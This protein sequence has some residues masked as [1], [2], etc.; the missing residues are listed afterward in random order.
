MRSRLALVLLFLA[1]ILAFAAPAGALEHTFS[2]S[3]QLD[4]LGVPTQPSWDANGGTGQTFDGFTMEAAVKVSADITDHLSANV[5]VCFGC[6]GFELDMAYFDLRVADELNFRVGRFSPSFG[7]FTLRHDPA[8]QKLSDKPLP[9]DMGRMLRNMAW[10]YSVLPS[11]F[12]DNGAEID[13]THWFGSSAQLDYAAYA[14]AGF[15]NTDANPT[16]IN[17]PLSH[18]YPYAYYVDNNARPAGG[19]RLALTVKPSSSSDI[20]VG[21]SGMGGTYDNNDRLTYIILG[22]DASVRIHRTNIRAEYLVRRTEISTLPGAQ[23]GLK[24]AIAADDGNYFVKHG[25]YVELEQPVVH[26][27]DAIA[28]VDGM[29]RIGNVPVGSLLTEH[30]WMVRETLG[31]AYGI[32]RNLRL[33][34]SVEYYEFSEADL[35]GNVRDLAFHVGVTGTF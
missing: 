15:R 29:A 1:A 8:N 21:T 20:T 35:A 19:A 14:V 3:L 11:P 33:K 26:D 13:G 12:P 27:L 22:A 10:G 6:H 7:A 28:R 25:A 4:Y 18:T 34:G 16:D 24:Y 5:K 31:L 32:E 23:S 30:S 2:G 17:F 9:Y